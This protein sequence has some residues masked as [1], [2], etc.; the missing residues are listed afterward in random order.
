MTKLIIV[1]GI[2]LLNVFGVFTAEAY[3]VNGY[4]RSS[5]TY[6]RPYYRTSPDSYLW[7]NYS[8]S[9]PRSPSIYDYGYNSSLYRNSYTPSYSYSL[10]YSYNWNSSYW[11]W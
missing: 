11:N 6:V 1:I 5:G 2:L 9:V 8:Y 7:N 4:Y 3:Y 10:P